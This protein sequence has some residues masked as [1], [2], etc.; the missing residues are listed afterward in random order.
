MSASQVEK[1]DVKQQTKIESLGSEA[2][3]LLHSLIKSGEPLTVHFWSELQNKLGLTE[4]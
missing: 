3:V 2:L 4:Q 1:D